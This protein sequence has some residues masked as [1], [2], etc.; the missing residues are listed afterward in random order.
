VW[1]SIMDIELVPGDVLDKATAQIAQGGDGIREG[2]A[3][4]LEAKLAYKE[5]E[6]Q[7][8]TGGKNCSVLLSGALRR[9]HDDPYLALGVPV[10]AAEA[11]IKK[12]YRKLALRFHPDKSR[13]TTSLFQA[14]QG[15]NVSATAESC[16]V[17]NC[18]LSYASAV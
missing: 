6:S 12:A 9:L 11:D 1:R 7:G 3:A 15:A 13:A 17:Y 18:Q 16:R 8:I 10:A 4:L 14:I 5:A 2:A